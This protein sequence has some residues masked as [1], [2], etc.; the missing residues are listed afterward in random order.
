[1]VISAQCQGL[2]IKDLL[3]SIFLIHSS[4]STSPLNHQE[5]E[6]RF[7]EGEEAD[8]RSKTTTYNY[9]FCVAPCKLW[10]DIHL[11]IQNYKNVVSDK[12]IELLWVAW[13]KQ[14]KSP[15]LLVP[16][17]QRSF[18]AGCGSSLLSL[19]LPLL[20][21]VS[22]KVVSKP[23][24]VMLDWQLNS[25]VCQVEQHHL[26]AVRRWTRWRRPWPAEIRSCSTT[27]CTESPSRS[28]QSKLSFH[29]SLSVSSSVRS[30]VV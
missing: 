6:W 22:R 8:K 2:K 29:L 14:I 10:L 17:L 24:T 21:L 16:S 26:R 9:L 27:G 25:C 11:S 7:E 3:Y 19:H 12:E 20:L 13:K 5:T 15:I 30:F 28:F 1:M 4:L 18:Y 23:V